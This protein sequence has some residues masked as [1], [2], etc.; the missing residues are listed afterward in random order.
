MIR[1]ECRTAQKGYAAGKV[2]M[3]RSGGADAYR[4]GDPAEECARLEAAAAEMNR[5]LEA[6]KES[7]NP[8][9]AAVIGAEVMLLNG[10]EF[11]GA[12]RRGTLEEKL[13][14][15]EAVK[16]AADAMCALLEGSG[17]DY[18][19]QRCEDIRGLA[20]GLT[21]LITG[22]SGEAPAEPFILAGSELS[23]GEIT[24]A[25]PDRIRGILTETGSPTSH[26]SV[27]AGNMGIPYIYGLKGLAEKVRDGD[28]LIL[29]A[30]D[31]SVSVN[32]SEDARREAEARQAA[33]TEAR[34][35]Q[36]E[37]AAGRST[38][39]KICAN[40]GRAEEADGL[41]EAGAD[42]I[43]LFRSEFLFLNR[44]EA[45]GEEE[46]FAAYRRAAEAM[47]GRETVIRT[48]DIGSDKRAAWLE[49]PEE[50]NPALGLRG[51]RVSLAHR[52][53][54]RTQLRALLRAAVYGNI[55]I[56]V[57]MIASAWE[58][59]EVLEEIRTAAEE[60]EK[61]GEKYRIP[62][63]GVMIET[64]AAVMIAPELAEKA[65]FFSIG[66][67]DLAQYTLAVDREAKG[68]DRYFMP[69]HQAVIRMI[70]MAAEA[71]HR[72][73]IPAAVC[74]ELAGDPQFT[75]ELI[76][77]GA[78]ELSVSPAKLA[79]VRNR[80]ADVEESMDRE[81]RE[82]KKGGIRSPAEGELVPM[83]EIPDPVFSG[84][85]MGECIGID[86]A[87]GKIYAPVSGTVATVAAARHAVSFRGDDGTEILVHAGLDTVKLNGEG[88]RV[89]VREG[90][91][92]EQ[93]QLVMEA[94]IELI[95]S[96]GFDPMIIVVKLGTAT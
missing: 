86:S 31:G 68:M 72:K 14:A 7:G 5:R 83:E 80:A 71:A 87:D 28:Y 47:G 51:V 30:E 78:D 4:P 88:F 63:T 64:P 15:P 95:R 9:Q 55:R 35:T 25:G 23:P 1:Y 62:E 42:G 20:A 66:T 49:M 85:I 33:D 92:V 69:G 93:G 77:A 57:P 16:R 79:E 60:L 11:L 53:L 37:R 48:M 75:E 18:I 84:G 56:M 34:K 6:G 89:Y 2:Y 29:D 24:L 3:L 96:R 10:D 67:N 8:E 22:G 74:G 65:R 82:K 39:I 81:C 12:A 73:G 94:D 41:A 40:I 59:D 50:I 52:E 44:A 45:P 70:A 26:V 19:R 13:P 21:A 54:F 43:G 17:Q 91:K 90:E 46:Q 61:R 58:L 36:R 27:L 38:R 76:R 32:P